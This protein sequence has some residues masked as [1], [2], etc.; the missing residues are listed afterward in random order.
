MLGGKVRAHPQSP[1]R[2]SPSSGAG[3]GD[4]AGCRGGPG[5]L[6]QRPGSPWLG[7]ITPKCLPCTDCV[8]HEHQRGGQ[9]GRIFLSLVC[10]LSLNQALEQFPTARRLTPQS[11]SASLLLPWLCRSVRGAKITQALFYSYLTFR[12]LP[13]LR[14]LLSLLDRVL[15]NAEHCL[16]SK[17][18]LS[19]LL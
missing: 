13:A 7:S 10:K 8:C 16:K 9:A 3:A 12:C 6:W 18:Q 4:A 1:P 15:L 17:V 19:L 14:D 2:G 11:F 5:L